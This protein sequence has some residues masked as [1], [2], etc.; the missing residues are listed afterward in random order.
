MLALEIGEEPVQ[1]FCEHRA[2]CLCVEG[3]GGR[4]EISFSNT[5]RCSSVAE[6]AGAAAR[7]PQPTIP[8]YLQDTTLEGAAVKQRVQ[9]QAALD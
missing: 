2:G 5:E 1:P 3:L 6:S 7:T 4:R 9:G 8:Q